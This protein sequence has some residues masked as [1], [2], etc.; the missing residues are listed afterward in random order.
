MFP[1]YR[2]K[3]TRPTHLTSAGDRFVAFLTA[4]FMLH[5]QKPLVGRG[6]VLSRLHDHI[7]DTHTPTGLLWTSDQAV[8]ENL[9]DNAQYSQEISMLSAGFEPVFSASERPQTHASGRTVTG[10]GRGT[11]R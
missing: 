8:A 10:I 6:L 3:S 11:Y 1:P 5:A 2:F 7:Q 9:S 4:D